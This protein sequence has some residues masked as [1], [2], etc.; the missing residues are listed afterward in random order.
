M[1]EVK[2]DFDEELSLF[3]EYYEPN[4]KLKCRVIQ[5]NAFNGFTVGDQVRYGPNAACGETHYPHGTIEFFYERPDGVGVKYTKG[6]HD[7]I[8]S[9][10]KWKK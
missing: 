7:R 10:I 2:I 3:P 1:N 6:G 4:K 5:S 9:V 8:T